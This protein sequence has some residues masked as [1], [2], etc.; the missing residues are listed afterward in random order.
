MKA[1]SAV[2]GKLM[3]PSGWATFDL[4]MFPWHEPMERFV[5]AAD[6]ADIEYL[7]PKIGEVVNPGQEGGRKAWW[8]LFINK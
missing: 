5:I 8:K 4:G 3:V 7:T 2:R 1:H 6:K